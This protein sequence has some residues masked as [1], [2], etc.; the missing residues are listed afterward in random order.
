[1]E[2]ISVVWGLEEYT[3]AAKKKYA[4][5]QRTFSASS[6]EWGDGWPG[7][8]KTLDVAYKYCKNFTGVSVKEGG[9]IQLP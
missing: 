8:K 2:I 3:E 6:D 7:Y 9:E 4:S 1:M 5:G